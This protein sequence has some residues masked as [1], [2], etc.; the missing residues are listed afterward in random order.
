MKY[1]RTLIPLLAPLALAFLSQTPLLAQRDSNQKP[2]EYDQLFT[3]IGIFV[4]YFQ[5]DHGEANRH[6][7]THMS[8]RHSDATVLHD[9]LARLVDV[10][11]AKRIGGAYLVTH[12]GQRAKIES[13]VEHIYPT[14]FDPPEITQE[15][16]GPFSNE[17]DLTTHLTPTAF[18]TR[19]TGWTL[20]VDPVLR[21][22]GETVDLN[23]ATEN[24]EHVGEKDW[25]QQESRM[26]QPVFN[27]MRNSTAIATHSGNWALIGMHKPSPTI[28]ALKAST[29]NDMDERIIVL[30]RSDVLRTR[31]RANDPSGLISGNTTISTLAEY[32][33]VGAGEA[34]KLLANHIGSGSSNP[35][36]EQLDALIL[37][38]KATIVDTASVTTR[39]GQRAKAE[40][41]S[42]WIF[43]T[44]M[45]PPEIPQ[46]LTG[47]IEKG[48]DLITPLSYTAFETRNIGTTLEVDP[49]TNATTSGLGIDINIA[50]EIVTY[51]GETKYG[52]AESQAE[53]PIFAALKTST[54]VTVHSNDP[55]LIGVFM[56]LEKKTRKPNSDKRVF[57]FITATT[58]EVE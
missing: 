52:Q 33:E 7:R 31:L 42:E 58:L 6:V 48:A 40:S 51:L 49:V 56:P 11:K 4:E 14:E 18:E 9:A 37:S 36:R 44:E 26:S 46:D 17:V 45:D 22:D 13:I 38:D 1:S 16:K 2:A 30:V 24:V 28:N 54:A 39:S 32:I 3:Q 12:S 21:A 19:N 8:T 23:I 29:A 5:L 43:P 25:G 20:E 10:Q 50:P 55:L 57:L 27:S 47:P 53:M 15:L 34:A 35:L 41:V